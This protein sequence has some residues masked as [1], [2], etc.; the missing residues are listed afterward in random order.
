[1]SLHI[2]VANEKP[3]WARSDGSSL[4]KNALLICRVLFFF[5]EIE[6]G[7]AFDKSTSSWNLLHKGSGIKGKQ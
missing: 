6:D 2:T 1:M 3:Y 7:I 4:S 5:K